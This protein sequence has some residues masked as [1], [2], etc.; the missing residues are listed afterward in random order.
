MSE[1]NDGVDKSVYLQLGHLQGQMDSVLGQLHN[2]GKQTYQL[3]TMTRGEIEK[4]SSSVSVRITLLENRQDATDLRVAKLKW[5]Q[6]VA[7]SAIATFFGVAV[8]IVFHYWR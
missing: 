5:N 3:E 4:L 1:D 7:S 6:A 8:Q 2:I